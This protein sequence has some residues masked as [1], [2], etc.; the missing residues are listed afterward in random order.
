MNEFLLQEVSHATGLVCLTLTRA[1]DVRTRGPITCELQDANAGID[2]PYRLIASGDI[3]HFISETEWP[4][5]TKNEAETAFGNDVAYAHCQILFPTVRDAGS[6][7]SMQIV[8]VELIGVV[9]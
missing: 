9:Q 5:F 7:N 4:R 2:G 3:V 8:E 6:A 1:N